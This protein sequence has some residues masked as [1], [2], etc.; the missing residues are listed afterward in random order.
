MPVN[1]KF[2]SEFDKLLERLEGDG[3]ESFFNEID[4][5]VV[6]KLPCECGGSRRYVGLKN[7]SIDSYCAFAICDNCGNWHEF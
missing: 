6:A 2:F 5:D 1:D 7:Y 3:Y 4:H